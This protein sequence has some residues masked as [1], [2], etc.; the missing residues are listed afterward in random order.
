MCFC[1]SSIEEYRQTNGNY[2][3][4]WQPEYFSYVQGKIYGK[5]SGEFENNS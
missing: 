5:L 3:T 2:D 1:L 4:I